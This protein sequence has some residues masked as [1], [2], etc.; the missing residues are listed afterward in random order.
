[1]SM[2]EHAAR[3]APLH[4]PLAV[5]VLGAPLRLFAEVLAGVGAFAAWLERVDAA[6]WAEGFVLGPAAG[7]AASPPTPASALPVL[8]HAHTQLELARRA[9]RAV[10]AALVDV[11]CAARELARMPPVDVPLWDALFGALLDESA[12]AHTRALAAA[13]APAVAS[14]RRLATQP[15]CFYLA[16]VCEA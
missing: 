13:L 16:A 8:E 4:A 5:L 1:M 2:L 3:G 15:G 12:D 6:Q 9:A 11:D 14:R 10:R 7:A